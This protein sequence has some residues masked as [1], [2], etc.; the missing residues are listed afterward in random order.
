MLLASC[1]NDEFKAEAKASFTAL[2]A[3]SSLM[4]MIEDGVAHVKVTP[5]AHLD[6]ALDSS[7]DQDVYMAFMAQPFIEAGLDLTALPDTPTV[8]C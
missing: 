1:S 2:M 7:T 8:P 4:A 3:S 5:E 6:F